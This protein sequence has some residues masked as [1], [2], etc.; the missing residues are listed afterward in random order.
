[1]SVVIAVDIPGLGKGV[2][3]PP[4]YCT[5]DCICHRGADVYCECVPTFC[6]D[7]TVYVDEECPTCGG[8]G[9]VSYGDATCPRCG[10]E[11][12]D[13][14]VFAGSGYVAVPY[15]VTQVLRVLGPDDLQDVRG[16]DAGGYLRVTTSGVWWHRRVNEGGL[17]R[18]EASP[19]DLPDAQPGGVCLV[20]ERAS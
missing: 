17:R 13:G 9:L 2:V 8:W 18:W 14:L 4:C 15:T 19:I 5:G 11:R 1:M 12:V 20:V 16:T 7:D 6:V 3:L 10:T